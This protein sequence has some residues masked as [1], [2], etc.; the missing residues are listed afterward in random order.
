M[1]RYTQISFY[2][3]IVYGLIC[4]F[5]S[6]TLVSSEE[7]IPSSS[8]ELSDLISGFS[9]EEQS[10]LKAHPT[11]NIGGPKSFPPFH[12]Y[13]EDTTLK[14]ISADYI[15]FIMEQLGINLKV[16]K[17]IPWPEVLKKAESGEIDLIPCIAQTEDRKKFLYF[18]NPYLSFPL[19]IITRNDA[20]F[21]GGIEDLHDKKLATIQKV[22]TN[23]WLIRDGVKFIPVFVD[24][25]LDGLKS[26][27]LGQADARIEN[28]AAATYL[29]RKYGL[30]N[31]KIAAPT[32]Y[33]NYNLHMGVNKNHPELVGIINKALEVMPPDKHIEIRNTWLSVRYE[34]GIKKSDVIQWGLLLLLFICVIFTVVLIWNRRLKAEVTERKQ[35]Q[36]EL[37]SSKQLNQ[38]IMDHLPIGIAV[39]SIDPAVTFNFIN[40]NFIKFYRTTRD[41]LENPDNFWEAVYEDP[42]YR[43][44]IRKRVLDDCDSG[45]VNRMHWEDIP[46]SRAGRETRYISA[47]NTP[48]PESKLMI[49]S[50]WDVTARNLALE[51]LKNEKEFTDTALNS[52]HDTFF[53]FEPSTGKAIRWN[54]AFRNISG[55]SDHEISELKAPE[56]YYSPEDLDKTEALINDVLDKGKATIT[57]DLICKDGHTVPTEYNVSLIKDEQGQ[58]KYL[59]SIGRD[60]RERQLA[61]SEKET[62]ESQLTQALKME[63]VGTMAGGIAHDFNN[64]LGIII[65]NAELAYDDVPDW[66]PARNNL[67]EIKTACLRAR[68]VVRQ[69]LSFSRKS[70]K[71]QKPILIND[72]VK[73]S[74]KLMRASLPTSISIEL[75]IPDMSEIILADP[76]QIHQILINLCTNSSHAMET[77]GGILSVDLK[78]IFLNETSSEPNSPLKT[79]DYI[80]ITVRDT[81]H[82]IPEDIQ[83]KIFDPYYTTKEVGKGSGMGLSVVHGI[84]ENHNGKLSLESKPGSGT[85]IHVMLPVLTG[86]LNV[87]EETAAVKNQPGK[88]TILFVDDEEPITRM[89]E[90]ILKKL[91]YHVHITNQPEQALSEF[92]KHPE[93]YDLVI[94]DMTMPH[95]SGVQ[96]TEKLKSVKPDIPVIICTGH[97]SQIDENK[98]KDTGI[99]AFAMKP[100]TSSEIA[101]LIRSVLDAPA[102]K[103]NEFD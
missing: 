12:Y 75:N 87:D 13:D 50:V 43:K 68:D 37:H 15:R 84:V 62:L 67:N 33:G 38:S 63:A 98:A 101:Q 55:Y 7:G 44:I 99:A 30:T 39:N 82:G 20:S 14:G 31:L 36:E 2:R 29:I 18:S 17:N 16:H 58:P 40:D 60:I 24:S 80:E 88:E 53:L 93:S 21:I 32:P 72:I 26:V 52:Q 27:S 51:N 97:S 100:I 9:A 103:P 94:S 71:K 76:T 91:G 64:I 96:L 54:Q 10:W 73:E 78:K 1:K 28:L 35:V 25:P 77:D 79:G 23:E 89:A 90:I 4:L 6:V 48:V 8:Q 56:S 41:D 61:A 95:M 22:S 85:S 65:G 69:L 59:I 42:D 49:S 5:L 11:L 86:S 19:V 45:D 81:G 92:K 74:M 102:S 70:E 46:V 83:E 34:Y 3:N 66:N 57:L 47:S